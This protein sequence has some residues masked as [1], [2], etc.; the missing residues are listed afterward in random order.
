MAAGDTAA[1]DDKSEGHKQS[2]QV[3]AGE[4]VH[5]AIEVIELTLS[6]G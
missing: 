5:A 3:A 4:Q 1:L 6:K 2:L